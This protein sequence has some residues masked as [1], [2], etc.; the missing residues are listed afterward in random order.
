[1]A[2]SDLKLNDE[3]FAPSQGQKAIPTY[4]DKYNDLIEFIDELNLVDDIVFTGGLTLA[5]TAAS[6]VNDVIAP[7][8]TKFYGTDPAG[9]KG[10]QD[11][12]IP[13]GTPVNNQV[14]IWTSATVIEGDSDFTWDGSF[15]GITGGLT[16]SDINTEFGIVLTDASGTL[17]NSTNLTW[18]GVQLF[19]QGNSNITGQFTTTGTD[20][21]RVVIGGGAGADTL[22]VWQDSGSNVAA[23]GWDAATDELLITTYGAGA[24][25]LDAQDKLASFTPSGA[26]ELYYNNSKKFETTSTGGVITGDLGITGDIAIS[27]LTTANAVVRSDASG[28][29]ETDSGLT[30]DGTT[31]WANVANADIIAGDGFGA[32]GVNVIS[33]TG[34]G[35]EIIL[36]SGATWF[37]IFHQ[38]S[39]GFTNFN[40]PDGGVGMRLNNGGSVDLYYDNVKKFETSSTG[41]L[42]TGN[43]RISGV[44]TGA[45]GGGVSSGSLWQTEGHDTLPD[46][47]LMIGI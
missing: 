46:G 21:N 34:S 28:Q 6:L 45:T 32:A 1:M 19:A 8:N 36:Q 42:V 41:A 38:Q 47:V 3:N 18:N 10:W 43:L 27:G 33:T 31:L 44:P 2:I 7:G 9:A 14:A 16:V 11:A 17:E 26:V 22:L 13:T 20:Y 39:L 15:V 12:V 4:I 29:L 30:W 40:N 37:Q 5:V 25:A 23:M 35:A 24:G